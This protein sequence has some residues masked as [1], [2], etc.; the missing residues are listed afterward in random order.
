MSNPIELSAAP[1]DFRAL[2]D[3]VVQS[4]ETIVLTEEGKSVAEL[5]PIERTPLC[6]SE[7]VRFLGETPRLGAEEAEA[8]EQDLLA[9]RDGVDSAGVRSP[10]DT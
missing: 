10:W 4:G 6:L 5:R 7:L 9:A 1:A 3:Q 8:F 2:V